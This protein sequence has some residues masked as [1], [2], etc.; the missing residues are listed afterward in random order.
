MSEEVKNAHNESTQ[1]S[2]VSTVMQCS[3]DIECD[4]DVSVRTRSDHI[5]AFRSLVAA[6]RNSLSLLSNVRLAER[7]TGDKITQI[8]Q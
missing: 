6:M 8:R 1:L 2:S 7:K 5:V 3:P 4:T